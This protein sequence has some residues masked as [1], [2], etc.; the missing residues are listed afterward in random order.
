[1]KK[2]IL[3]SEKKWHDNIFLQLSERPGEIW[4]RIKNKDDFS[5]EFLNKFKP[6]K[7]FIPHWSH[8]IP[9]SIYNS[10]ECVVFHMTDLPYGRGGSPLQNLIIN[11][12]ITTKISALKVQK[13]IDTGDIYLKKKV[14]L[15][16]TAYSIFKRSSLVIKKMI[17][18]IIDEQITPTKQIGEVVL[19]KRRKPE[20][21][22]LVNADDLNKIHDMIRMLDCPD[23]PN[24]F[25]ELKNLRFEF[26][27]SKKN[28][29]KNEI[30]ANVRIFKK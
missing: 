17:E 30:T 11:G 26:Y 19:F 13:G 18:Q 10:F 1:M 29:N 15:N 8:I 7:I 23:Y 21:G 12:H 28:N 22:N 6:D 4:L 16:G 5:L 25:L 3:L 14:S 24:A 2:Y 20:D 9:S 27:K